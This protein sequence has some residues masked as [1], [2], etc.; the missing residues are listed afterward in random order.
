MADTPQKITMSKNWKIYRAI[1]DEMGLFSIEGEGPKDRFA[2]AIKDG[3]GEL[4]YIIGSEYD[5]NGHVVIRTELQG[6]KENLEYVLE[7]IS[8]EK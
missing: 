7:L 3:Y 4:C 8:R 2:K 5:N 6:K 1:Y